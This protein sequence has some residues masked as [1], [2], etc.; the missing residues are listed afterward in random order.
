[1]N[2][3]R[4]RIIVA[5]LLSLAGLAAL[6]WG[7]ADGVA[8]LEHPI[9]ARQAE[10][11][12]SASC[13][14]CHDDRHDSWYRTFHRSMTQ[15]A[16]SA[17]VQGQFD[18]RSLDFQGIRVRPVQQD[19][20][21]YF[22][23]MDLKT[24]RALNRVEIHRTVG[25]NRYQQYL[26]R[27]D[28]DG[29]YVRLH[30]LWH[31]GDQ[32]WVHMNAVFLG[33]DDRPYD[34]NVAIWN[35]NCIFCHNTG[36]EP[37]I[38][39]DEELRSRARAGEPVNMA[40]DTRF[41]SVVAE[42]G[43]SCESCHGPGSE[44]V[45]R[46]EDFWTRQAMRAAPGADASIINPVRHQDGR[47]SQVCAQ[48]HAQRV[49]A[50]PSRILE[51]MHDGPSYRPGDD[52]RAHVTPVTR[53]LK[54]PIQGQEDLFVNR[55]WADG[56]PRLTAYEYQGMTMS[57]G[58][59]DTD[60]SCMD[61]HTM[62]T[63]DPRGQIT[64]RQRG[65]APCLR[66]HTD[67]RGDEALAE[68]TLHPVDSEASNC[69][70]CH[71]PEII[72]GV[73]DIHRSHRIESP[74]AGR[75]AAAGRPNACLNCHLEQSPGWAARELESGWGTAAP[76]TIERLD[77]LPPELAE[78]ATVLAGDPVQKA[79]TAYR[80]GQSDHQG[81]ALER[82]WAVPFLL[83]AMRDHYPSS[84]RFARASLIALLETWPD[85]GEAET[86]LEPIRRFDFTAPLEARTA[87]LDAADGAWSRFDRS[88][89]P[90][91]PAA[92]GLL[93][94]Y[95]LPAERVAELQRIGQRQDKQI[96]IGE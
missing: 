44:H 65:N 64:E 48:C 51:W 9:D 14:G 19:G 33:A 35:Q 31:N 53:E 66:C 77:G 40:T 5:V 73:M 29:T 34:Q 16:S 18:G 27:I 17:S 60:L 12:G 70:S 11:V 72:Y 26:T 3:L 59:E 21:Y 2:P 69:Y 76:P 39:N 38:L 32:R 54:A 46:A 81:T 22:D 79:V 50:D 28:E 92:S 23:Y 68:H 75:D 45:D 20:R 93:T 37:R 86:L 4:P 63:G 15:E 49:P 62:H 58:H 83:Q 52:L 43:I 94:D 6:G 91:V 80:A 55:F 89:W 95:R 74:D 36:I 84:R 41:A 10:Y 57:S 56:T 61:C 96:D 42:L 24:G 88:D 25:S 78:I 30:Y 67:Y 82:A 87:I 8:T 85:R 90:P 7:L 71:M 13:S 1:M 47:G